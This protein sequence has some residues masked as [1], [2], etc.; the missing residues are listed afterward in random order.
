RCWCRI[1]VGSRWNQTMAACAASGSPNLTSRS[2]VLQPDSR[3]SEEIAPQARALG[4]DLLSPRR[5]PRI[6]LE[7]HP[8]QAFSPA[9]HRPC[10]GLEPKREQVS[11]LS[12]RME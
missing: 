7:L 8:Q 10:S 3:L 12:V 1:S 11:Q 4:E 9:W 5:A 2:T 6:F